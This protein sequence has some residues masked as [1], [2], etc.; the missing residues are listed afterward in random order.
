MADATN[1]FRTCP[2]TGLQWHKPSES[3]IKAN[4]V[5]AVVALLI[6]G[7]LA[8]IMVLTRWQAVHLVGAEDF[9]MYLTA[10]GLAMLAYWARVSASVWAGP[11][12]SVRPAL[13]TSRLPPLKTARGVASPVAWTSQARCSGV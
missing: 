8:I 3:L 10:H 6:G 9:Y 7:V 4:A 13:P 12:R 5:A 1:L 11:S 2:R